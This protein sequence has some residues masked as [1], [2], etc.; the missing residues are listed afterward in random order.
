MDKRG[1]KNL[2]SM[3]LTVL[4][5]ALY[6]LPNF[7]S[8][9]VVRIS[10]DKSS[11]ENSEVVKFDVSVDIDDGERIPV[12]NLTLKV[13]NTIKQCTFRPDGTF[14]SGCD[15]MN[16]TSKSVFNAGYGYGY[17]NHGYGYGYGYGYGLTNPSE[18]SYTIEWDIGAEGLANGI[19]EA[20]LEAFAKNGNTEF[21]YTSKNPVAFEVTGDKLVGDVNDVDSDIPD[22]GLEIGGS[23]NLSNITGTKPVVFKQGSDTLVEFDWDFS[24]SQLNLGNISIKSSVVNGSNRIIVNGINLPSG[25][26][27]TVYLNQTNTTLNSVCVYDHE[28]ASV[29]TMSN[30]CNFGNETKVECNGVAQSGFTCTKTGTFLKVAGLKHSG[31]N[32]ISYTAP[33]SPAPSG[34][35][36]TAAAAGGGGGSGYYWECG[37]WSACQPSGI[38]TRSCSLVVSSSGSTTKPEETRS[39]TYTAPAET[40][41]TVT[42]TA[43]TT[44]TQ[45]TPQG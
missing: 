40:P 33:V 1:K 13:N 39:C 43:P 36:G 27:K 11:Y 19:Y 3:L 15:N 12:K 7:A 2:T 38:Q 4:V 29:S 9:V 22:L 44:A 25:V 6:L 28:I 20:N 17:D 30:N 21:S 16:I 14:I 23:T 8:A 42:P 34:D 24:S 18:L 31:L 5:L 37:E 35:G 32:Q 41:E 26:T 45:T 10:T